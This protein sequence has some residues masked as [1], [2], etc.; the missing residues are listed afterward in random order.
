[1][2]AR[3]SSAQ[4]DP[5]VPAR[6]VAAGST[7]LE[8]SLTG[9]ARAEYAAG[10]A[11]L[12][13]GDFGGALERFK[14]AHA[15]S[16]DA[17]LY[18]SLGVCERGLR[19]YAD[20]IRYFEKY[21]SEGGAQLTEEDLSAADEIIKAL[22]ARLGASHTP[23]PAVSHGRLTIVAKAGDAISIDGRAVGIASYEATLPSG[24]HVVRVTAQGRKP[25]EQR[26]VIEDD[27]VRTLDVS[28]EKDS[29]VLPLWAMIGVGAAAA[30]GLVVIG[31][32]VLRSDEEAQRP[33]RGTMEPGLVQLPSW[34]FP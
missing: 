32:L 10:R 9:A 1:M 15:A 14:A 17:R 22:R 19:H 6:V 28:L 26:V 3:S 33:I 4:E 8:D 30:T 23:P 13:E 16:K 27:Q 12:D 7:S 21:K 11:L 31:Y 24:V 29:M 5:S 18:W 2:M 34:R 25:F 20:A